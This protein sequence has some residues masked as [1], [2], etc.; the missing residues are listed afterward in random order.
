MK[1]ASQGDVLRAMHQGG[2]LT[3]EMESTKEGSKAH[4]IITG[5]AFHKALTSALIERLILDGLVLPCGD[6]LFDDSQTYR[7]A[8]GQELERAGR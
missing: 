4:W 2:T 5:V 8:R 7:L 1:R 3:K 6:G